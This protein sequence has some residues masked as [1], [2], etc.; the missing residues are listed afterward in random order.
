[1]RGIAVS[2]KP[3]FLDR[4]PHGGFGGLVIQTQP[5]GNL[6]HGHPMTG[7]AAAYPYDVLA[8]G[9]GGIL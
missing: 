6:V 3:P 8:H 5:L 7:S 2:D 1:M 9:A 4:A